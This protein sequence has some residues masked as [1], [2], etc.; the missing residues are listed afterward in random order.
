MSN[1]AAHRERRRVRA[2]D[3]SRRQRSGRVRRS[4]HPRDRV[5]VPSSEHREVIERLTNRQRSRWAKLGYLSEK[6]SLVVSPPPP[7]ARRRARKT[8]D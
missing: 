6:L 8:L 1:S 7:R 5:P 2:R 4:W 3:V